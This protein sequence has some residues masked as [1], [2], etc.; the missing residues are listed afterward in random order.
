LDFSDDRALTEKVIGAAMKVHRQLGP[1]F[2]ES[3]Y[4]NA[5]ALFVS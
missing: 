1:G 3:V 2:L 5:L 4:R